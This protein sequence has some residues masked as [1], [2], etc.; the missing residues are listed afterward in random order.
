MSHSASGVFARWNLQITLL[1]PLAIEQ[2]KGKTF[3]T[4][5]AEN[6]SY[7]ENPSITPLHL[8]MTKQKSSFSQEKNASS[9]QSHLVR[10]PEKISLEQTSRFGQNSCAKVWAHRHFHARID[11]WRKKT[12]VQFGRKWDALSICVSED[13]Y[14]GFSVRYF[15]GADIPYGNLGEPA[16][17]VLG[18][19]R[20]QIDLF[21]LL[22]FYPDITIWNIT[23]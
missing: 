20:Q 7:A 17:L 5:I 19:E 22:D 10:P 2:R 23:G 4:L 15:S 12:F 18:A 13:Y 9:L 11:I 14:K 8:Y 16:V 3:Q 1:G 6:R 21:C